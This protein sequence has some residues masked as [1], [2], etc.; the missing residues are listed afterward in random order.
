MKLKVLKPF[1]NKEDKKQVFEAG[2]IIDIADVTR[3]NDIV[4]RGLGEVIEKTAVADNDN[5]AGAGENEPTASAQPATV[6]DEKSEEKEDEKSAGVEKPKAGRSS[7]KPKK[8]DKEVEEQPEEG[9]A[10]LAPEEVTES[11]GTE[12]KE[13]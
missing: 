5:A 10:E 2:A 12:V 11:E 4:K 3:I 6:A 7:R 9:D 1:I 13:E 8:A